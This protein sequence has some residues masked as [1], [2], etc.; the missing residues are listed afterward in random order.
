MTA[1]QRLSALMTVYAVLYFGFAL[2]VLFAE[3]FV[4]RLL[5]L[6]TELLGLG[7]PIA[8]PPRPSFW[9]FV[10][11]GLI[12]VLGIISWWCRKPVA[13]RGAMIQL[14]VYC[15]LVSGSL[16]LLWYPLSGWTAAYLL[17]GLSDL[18]M[19]ALALVAYLQAVPGAWSRVLRLDP[20]D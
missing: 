7:S 4:F 6:Q 12:V 8:G 19:G 14:M 9:R 20:G 5:N 18:A 1:E 17:G 16:M 15:K 3:P 11:L 10:A 2:T 13:G